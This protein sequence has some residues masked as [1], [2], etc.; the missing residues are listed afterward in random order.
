MALEQLPDGRWRVDIEPVKGKRFRK[1]LKTK[2]EALRFEAVCRSKCIEIPD[3]SPKPKDRRKLSILVAL[4]FDLHGHSLRDAPRRR[5]KLDALVKRLSDPIASGFDP[6][7]YMQ[8]RRQRLSGGISSKTLNNELGYL[9][10]VFNELRALGQIDY[11]NPLALVKPLRLQERELS[12]LTVEQVS[13]LLESIR[14]GCDNPHVEPIV[15]I[16]LAT[17]ARWSEAEHLKP[18]AIRDRLVTFSTTKNGKVRS[19]PISGEL[20]QRL[21]KHWK[22]YG[23]FTSSITSFRRALA[24]T[25]IRL[26]K[27]QAAHALRHTFASHFMQNGGNILAL[28]KILGHSSLTMTMRYAHLAPQHLQEAIR[29]GPLASFDTLSTVQQPESKSP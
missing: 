18:S 29:L 2:A 11:Q 27:G 14:E 1:T 21:L 6:Q 12:W 17:G 24:R 5:A 15:L 22:Q 8:D 9:R 7:V 20:Y 28:Q 19:V 3:W 4:W 23:P 13:E 26:P 25:R 10:S 16:C